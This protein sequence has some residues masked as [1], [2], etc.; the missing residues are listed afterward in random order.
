MV[1]AKIVQIKGK[2]QPIRCKVLAVVGPANRHRIAF[3]MQDDRVGEGG[4]DQPCEVE[5]H[6]VLVHHAGLAPR[7][8]MQSTE[9]LA[10]DSH[11]CFLVE[12]GARSVRGAQA[13]CLNAP[14]IADFTGA[15]HL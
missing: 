2:G 11:Q 9:I 4:R 13:F 1:C 14:E 3:H 10:A 6:R 15:V 8:I 7:Q 12:R 5:I